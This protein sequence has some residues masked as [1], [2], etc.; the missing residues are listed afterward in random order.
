MKKIFNIEKEELINLKANITAE[1]IERQPRLWEETLAIIEKN[2]SKIETCVD[3]ALKTENIRIIFTGAGTSAYV[4]DT[5]APYLRK[6]IGVRVETIAT[7]DIITNPEEYFEKNTPTLLV[8]FARSG[9]SP[10]SLATYELAKQCVT[11][12]TQIVIT[13]NQEG[14]LAKKA[15]IDKE[16][17]VIFMPEE[18]NDKGF[19]MTGSFTCMLLTALLIFDLKELDKNK[20]YV[21]KIVERGNYILGKEVDTIRNIVDYE[22]ER[23]VFLGSSSMRGLA[24]EAALKILE[25]VSGKIITVSESVLG[26]RHGPKSIINDA[27]LV[28]MFMSKEAYTRKY[29]IDLLKEMHNEK[30]SKKVVAITTGRDLE[31]E[32][33][34]DLVLVAD[35]SSEGYQADVYQALPFILFAQMYALLIS[36]KLGITPDNPKPDGTVNRVVKGVNIYSYV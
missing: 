27:T 15:E 34:V 1:E 10:E 18:S 20:E 26:F 22:A 17:L 21:Q 35:E 9:N 28:F 12:I 25:L 19:A 24:T 31:I 2:M 8:S 29:E 32:E 4:G 14:S 5:I 6:K 33:N 16:N 11:D 36:I 23:I 3:K 30:G 13:C 7:T